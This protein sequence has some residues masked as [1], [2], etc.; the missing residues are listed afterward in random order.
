MTFGV[1]ADHPTH[2]SRVVKILELTGMP[3]VA[4]KLLHVSF[5]ETSHMAQQVGG[6]D[7]VLDD[8]SDLV[9]NPMCESLGANEEKP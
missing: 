9:Q 3:E 5:S 1:G 6:G 4:V 8:S 2:F 7:T